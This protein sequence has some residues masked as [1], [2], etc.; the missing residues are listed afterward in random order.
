MVF[1][2]TSWRC[3]SKATRS[4]AGDAF[5]VGLANTPISFVKHLHSVCV[6]VLECVCSLVR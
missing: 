6:C 5:E 3:T 4:L 2:C 1:I